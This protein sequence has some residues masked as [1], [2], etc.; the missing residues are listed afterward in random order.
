MAPLIFAP[1]PV[2]GAAATYNL[3]Q[4]GMNHTMGRVLQKMDESGIK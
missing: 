3:I 1:P 2:R 4:S